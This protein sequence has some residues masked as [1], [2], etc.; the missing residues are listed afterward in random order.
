M[1]LSEAETSARL[2]L[3]CIAGSPRRGGN[4][5]RLLNEAVA[6]AAAYG[7]NI[8]HITLADLEIS[9][10]QHCDGCVQTGGRCVVEDDMQW[11]QQDLRE[12]DRFILA[13]PIFFMGVTAQTKTMIDRCQALWVIKHLQKLPVG[14]NKERTRKGIFISVGG[15]SYTNLF[16]GSVATVKSWFNTLD[17]DYAGDLL[18]PGIDSYNAISTHPTALKDAFSL[19]RNLVSA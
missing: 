7:A 2:Q 6:G 17:V 15:T 4:T 14:L 11:I 13:S 10:C 9:P 12:F 8:K 1:P 5:D 19:G 3:L 18:I 16:Q